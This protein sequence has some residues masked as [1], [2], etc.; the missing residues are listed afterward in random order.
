MKTTTR[1]LRKNY[2][3]ERRATALEILGAGALPLEVFSEK[4]WAGAVPD[5]FG[6]YFLGGLVG[7]GLVEKHGSNGSE[8]YG[9]T[10][11]GRGLL[12]APPWKCWY[13]G[14]SRWTPGVV[15]NQPP[16]REC[17]RDH[18]ACSG[19]TRKLVVADG[20]FPRYRA[21]LREC[22]SGGKP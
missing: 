9:V 14:A 15:L 12:A 4:M 10:E 22:P 13:C 20:E 8:T 16:C 5:R 19:C 1:F 18:R 21:A 3:T 7:L 11:E 6:A 17:R 2:L